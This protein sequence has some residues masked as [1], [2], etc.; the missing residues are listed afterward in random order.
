MQHES[1]MIY[2]NKKILLRHG[3]YYITYIMCIVNP[4][5]PYAAREQHDL[6]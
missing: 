5:L 2:A 4:P 3:M 6:R 1:K